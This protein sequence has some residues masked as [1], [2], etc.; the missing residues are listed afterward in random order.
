MTPEEYIER[1][2][3]LAEQAKTARHQADRCLKIIG[4][5]RE[6]EQIKL[7][8]GGKTSE[9]WLYCEFSIPRDDSLVTLYQTIIRRVADEAETAV[10]NLDDAFRSGS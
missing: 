2:K 4:T 10:R 1:R 9:G 8:L 3:K 6:G 5:L 7:N